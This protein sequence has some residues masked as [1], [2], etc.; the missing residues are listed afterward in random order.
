MKEIPAGKVHPLL[1]TSRFK[2]G[3]TES[4]RPPCTILKAPG[5]QGDTDDDQDDRIPASVLEKLYPIVKRINAPVVQDLP[6]SALRRCPGSEISVDICFDCA[7]GLAV[8]WADGWGVIFYSIGKT[9]A[10]NNCRP[11]LEW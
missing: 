6:A 2:S 9:A 10:I 11:R 1:S 7:L 8:C 4:N 3:V 5:M